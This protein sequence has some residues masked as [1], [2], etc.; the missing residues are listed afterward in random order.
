MPK[1]LRIAMIASECTPFVKTGGLA[2]VLGSLPKALAKLGHELMVILPYYRQITGFRDDLRLAVSP[3]GVWMGDQ[4]EWCSSLFLEHEGVKFYFIDSRKFFDRYGLYHDAEFNDYQDNARRFGFFTRAALQLC[5]D[6]PFQADIVHCHDWQSALGPGYLKIWHWDDP[7]L[8]EA[9]SVLTIHNI[10][11][12]G[13]YSAADY[14]YLGLQWGN[15]TSDKFEDHGRVNFLK[16]GIHYADLVNTV[17]PTY[18]RETLSPEYAFGMAPYLNDRRES[19]LGVLN[20]V[21]Y[22]IWDPQTD[23]KIPAHFSIE[24]MSGKAEC[25]RQLQNRVFLDEDE[26]IPIFAVVSRLVRQK[27]LHLLAKTIEDILNQMRIQFVL[28]GSGEKD[29]ET[30]YGDLPKRFPGRVGSYIGYDDELSHWIEAGSDFFLM[31]SI[32]EP[33]GLNQIYSLRYGTLPVVRAT[34]GLEDTIEQYDEE[35]GGGTGFKFSEPSAHAIYYTVGWAASTFYDRPEHIKKMRAAAMSKDF[36][37]QAS[38]K[39]YESIYH[40]AIERKKKLR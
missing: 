23:K 40:Q 38:A 37:W 4:L 15:F 8:G 1:P 9:A 20:G 33:C 6:L 26:T 12:Q 32:Y 14:H 10:A 2:D 29:L 5:R 7:V 17:S 3:L 24:D 25:K 19:Y 16:G 30:Y 31:P 13:V 27:G 35:T 39:A 18:A 22:S 28:L 34:G 21:D 11:Y 36:S